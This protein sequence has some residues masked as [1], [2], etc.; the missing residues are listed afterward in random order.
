M[1]LPHDF[2]MAD[3]KQLNAIAQNVPTC[4]AKDMT[5]QVV[6]YLKGNLVLAE[7]TFLMQNNL[8]EEITLCE[9]L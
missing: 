9:P 1:G 8:K 6:E 4:T 7:N 3:R 2:E 5:T